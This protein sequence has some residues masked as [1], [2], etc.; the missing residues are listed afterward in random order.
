MN[1]KYWVGQWT[2][3]LSSE[4]VTLKKTGAKQKENDCSNPQEG[5][6][7]DDRILFF[8]DLLFGHSIVSNFATPWTAARQ[9]S[10]SFIHHLLELA[11]THVH[12]VC[13]AIQPSHS[14][15]PL[16]PSVFNLS[17]HQGLFQ[18]VSS[19]HQL[20]IEYN[21]LLTLSRETRTRKEVA[22]SA[23]P[24]GFYCPFLVTGLSLLIL[25]VAQW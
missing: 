23:T 24:S 4:S 18:W 3:I 17:Q 25:Q 1:F 20:F 15:L 2:E 22:R 11:Q 5:K 6:G 7:R 19:S 13:D 12:W 9:A 16:S 8:N 10:L 21:S 14:L